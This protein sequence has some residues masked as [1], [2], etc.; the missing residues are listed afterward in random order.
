MTDKRTLKEIYKDISYSNSPS[1]SSSL[2]LTLSLM[3]ADVSVRFRLTGIN[4]VQNQKAKVFPTYFSANQ[5]RSK[6]N[7]TPSQDNLLSI[8]PLQTDS[9]EILTNLSLEELQ[10]KSN[11]IKERLKDLQKNLSAHQLQLTRINQALI[12]KWRERTAMEENLK[13]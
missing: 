13:R 3:T 2:Q 7:T 1:R 11:A 9:V 4:G 5:T 12:L 6:F 8:M 10:E